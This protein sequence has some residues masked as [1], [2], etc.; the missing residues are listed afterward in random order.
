MKIPLSLY[1]LVAD[2]GGKEFGVD[3]FTVCPDVK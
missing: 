1:P 3:N 2:I